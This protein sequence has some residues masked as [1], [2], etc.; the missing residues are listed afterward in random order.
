MVQLGI[1]L[2]DIPKSITPAQQ[3]KDILRIVEAAQNQGFNHIAIGQHF[4]YGD[5]RWLQPVPLLARLAADVRPGHPAGHQHHDRAAVPPGDAGRGDR[6]PRRRH[7]GPVRLRRGPGL[8]AGGVRLPRR[9]VQGA[10]RPVQRVAGADEE[11]LDPGRRSTTRASTGSSTDVH[12]HIFPVQQPHPPIWIGAHAIPGVERAAKYGDGFVCPPETPKHEVAQRYKIVQDGFAARGKEFGPQPLRRNILVADTREE[13]IV[14]YARVAKGRYLT[15]AQKGLDV[16]TPEQLE[17]E[18]A[19]AVAGHAIIGTPDDVVAA[20]RRPRD[21]A[22]GRPADGAPA[23]ARDGHRGDDHDHRAHGPGDRAGA[24]GHRA[25]PAHPGGVP[26]GPGMSDTTRYYT[27]LKPVFADPETW[28]FAHVLRHWAEQRPDAL[29]PRL[30]GGAV[31]AH[32]RA[33]AGR[34]R[35]G[36]QRLLRRRRRAGRPRRRSWRPTPRGSSAPGSARPS[37][38][39]SRCRSTP[40]TRASSCATSSTSRRPGSPSSTTPSPSGGSPSPTHARDGREV[41]GHRHRPGHPRQG[42][43][44]AARERLGG[45]RRGTRSSRPSGRRCR[46]RARRTSA[47]SSSRPARP[48]RPRAWRCRTRS[49]TSS[50][51]SSSR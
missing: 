27:D 44:A 5:L 49:C 50:P 39:S 33:G 30:P 32:L 26:G 34:R 16:F 11:A 45:R 14:E 35:G 10:G 19:E 3:F 13:A 28:T 9:P 31:H 51:R 41:L 8:P 6:H 20:A 46:C 42:A 4:L 2:S 38:A 1:L 23:V 36:G 18:F 37:A 43:G 25:D 7:R 12:P 47:R 15:Y 17:K 29:L 40:T 48:A 22:P 24:E 21:H